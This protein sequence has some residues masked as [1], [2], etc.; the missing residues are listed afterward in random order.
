[1]RKSSPVC[2]S[3]DMHTQ[4]QGFRYS[5][6]RALENLEVGVGQWP[7]HRLEDH[8]S[9]STRGQGGGG[10]K[11]TERDKRETGG[12]GQLSGLL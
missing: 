11:G 12:R 8:R 4:C 6:S 5:G 10:A 7:Q 3:P 1:M 9:G 2:V